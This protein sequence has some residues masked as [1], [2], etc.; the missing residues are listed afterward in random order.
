MSGDG[1]YSVY[2]QMNV[3]WNGGWRAI[4]E[5]GSEPQR[6]LGMFKIKSLKDLQQEAL[7]KTVDD[8]DVFL[9]QPTGSRKFEL[10]DAMQNIRW[11][12]K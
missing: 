10:G 11:R 9:F 3:K 2:R 7:E 4:D 12:I 1:L 8:Q 6:I 5:S